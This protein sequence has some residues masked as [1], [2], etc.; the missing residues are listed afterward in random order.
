MGGRKFLRFHFIEMN[1][2]AAPQEL[3]CRFTAGKS[4]ANYY[5]RRCFHL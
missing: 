3:P 2:M 5:N 1:G 4:A